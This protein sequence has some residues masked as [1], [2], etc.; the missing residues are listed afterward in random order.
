MPVRLAPVRG[1][2][3]GT[4]EIVATLQDLAHPAVEAVTA[5]CTL[6]DVLELVLEAQARDILGVDA[7]GCGCGVVA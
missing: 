3:I 2:T 4:G 5:R 1:G 6:F 7:A